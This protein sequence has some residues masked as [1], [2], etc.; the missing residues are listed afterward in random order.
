MPRIKYAMDYRRRNSFSMSYASHKVIF[1]GASMIN[2]YAE[3]PD[4]VLLL[5]YMGPRSRVHE[6]SF[7]LHTLFYYL[8]LSD[9]LLLHKPDR[10]ELQLS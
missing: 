9:Q 7:R 2:D 10:A 6:Y 4:Q 8:E 3:S 1:P 5:M